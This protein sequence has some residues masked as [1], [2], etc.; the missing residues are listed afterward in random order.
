LA[1]QAIG[2]L[3]TVVP[4]ALDG[5]M[6]FSKQIAEDQRLLLA[7]I[8]RRIEAAL[9]PFANDLDDF[10][11]VL[12]QARLPAEWRQQWHGFV[13]ESATK[14]FFVN[15]KSVVEL[16]EWIEAWAGFCGLLPNG[17]E[18]GWQDRRSGIR[19]LLGSFEHRDA[20]T[21][22]SSYLPDDHGAPIMLASVAAKEQGTSPPKPTPQKPAAPA[23]PKPAAP[24]PSQTSAPAGK[25]NDDGVEVAG[26]GPETTVW[27]RK[28]VQKAL[29]TLDLRVA[30]WWNAN[31][32][33]G[34]VRSR[35]AAFWQYSHYSRIEE[36]NRPVIV[37]D[38]HYTAGQTAQA[39]IAEVTGGWF[40]DS[41]G[42][43]YKKYRFAQTLDYEEFR[44][45]QLGAAKEAARLAS[46]LAEM[47]LSGI[48]TLTPAGDLVLFTSD[49]M[50]RGLKL[51]QLV[52]LLPLAAHL[53]IGAIIVKFG[54]RQVKL[55]KQ[56]ARD[57]EKLNV[58]QRTTLLAKA[59]AAKTDDEAAAI[60]TRGIEVVTETEHHIATN[61]NWISTL[62]GG[63]WSPKF[64]KLFK[65]AG[66]T[67]E[68]AANKV[69]IPAHRGPHSEAYHQEIYDRLE[70]ATGNKSGKA[71]T[72]AFL[73][74]LRKIRIEVSTPGT[75]LNRLLTE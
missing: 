1:L 16:E 46:Q 25:F 17:S 13:A 49:V 26:P 65:K 33:T 5:T 23:S 61:K 8:H 7:D 30:R 9:Q 51:D 35:E 42:A 45:W 58:E 64:E 34:L 71:Y 24:T 75:K 50:E 57:F 31:S 10:L 6:D 67:L 43:F 21:I 22:L 20:S 52:N 37:V 38:E 48:A 27:Y 40:A 36:G 73:D 62:R 14:G 59:A 74:E 19:T 2:A 44:K 56:L 47:Y 72:K 39:I 15:P 54:K 53:P 66:L 3:A 12:F 41:I 18:F 11:E 60:I 69:P 70:L 29:E 32:V 28:K 63:P 68:D 4:L 55:G